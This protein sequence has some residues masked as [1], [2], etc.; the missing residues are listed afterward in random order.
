MHLILSPDKY[1]VR[2]MRFRWKNDNGLTF[3]KDFG[4][5][6]FR[7]PKYVVSFYTEQN[8]QTIHYGEGKFCSELHPMSSTESR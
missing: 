6:F 5:G 3:P 8:P 4:D 2:E 7:L 1:S